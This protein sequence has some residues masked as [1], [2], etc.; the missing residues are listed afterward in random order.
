MPRLRAIQGQA[1]AA[2]KSA[3]RFAP[4][5]REPTAVGG[6]CRGAAGEMT[7]ASVRV[8]VRVRPFNQR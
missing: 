7:D 5:I 4:K 8:A 2:A 1:P 3:A 6:E